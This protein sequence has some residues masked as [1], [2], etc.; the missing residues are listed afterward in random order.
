MNKYD[1]SKEMINEVKDYMCILK[2]IEERV[3][4]MINEV[5][6]YMRILKDIEERVKRIEDGNFSES[7]AE[8]LD[9]LF[10]VVEILSCQADDTS[11]AI[12]CLMDNVGH[13]A[14]RRREETYQAE[15]AETGEAIRDLQRDYMFSTLGIK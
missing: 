8:N 9:Q 4:E 15:Q 14:S 6:D 1:I 3:K 13:L 2:D 10:D 12:S 11:Y 5:R 7:R